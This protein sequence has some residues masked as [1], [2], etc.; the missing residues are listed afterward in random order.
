MVK[1]KKPQ[2]GNETKQKGKTHKLQK[3]W[4][5]TGLVAEITKIPQSKLPKYND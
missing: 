4:I 2:N 1:N 5:P 3:L